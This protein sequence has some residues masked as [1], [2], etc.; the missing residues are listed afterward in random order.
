MSDDLDE[1]RALLPGVT[2]APVGALGG[3]D[4][5]AV[6]R[7]HA[8][9]PD[10][11]PGAAPTTV[12]VKTFHEP[13]GWVREASALEVLPPSA[14]APRF[15]AAGDSPPVVVM[16]DLGPGTSVADALLGP[17]PAAAVVA[18]YAWTDA[19]AAVHRATTGHRD[20][21]RA[22]LDSRSKPGRVPLCSLTAGLD[23][24]IGDL[25]DLC[26]PLGVDMS[27]AL[28][29]AFH[30][31]AARLADEAACTLSPS[32]ACPDNNVLVGDSLMLI[33]FEGAAWRHVAWDIAY[34]KVP[35][36]SCW[37]SWR[38]PD[39]VS[40][41]AVARYRAAMADHLPYVATPAFERDIEAATD[42]WSVVYSSWFLPRALDADIVPH[43]LEGPSR[44][45]LLLHRLDRTWRESPTPVIAAFAAS[46]RA[47]LV[48]RW[49]D[50]P[51]ALAPA[52]RQL[53]DQ[54][55]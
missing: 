18:V 2:L 24:T 55:R 16:S 29:D 14:P 50:I 34:L 6:R 4:R 17:D 20:A 54:P 21:F 10:A 23:T 40:A 47:E 48:D 39:E 38:L 26:A 42:L 45:A 35:W 30:A 27:P 25:R 49:G 51:L 31:E 3:S 28:V 15:I 44:R 36:P 43:D 8:T 37:C 52:F 33:D 41:G 53:A 9:W 46:L 12:I 19:I 11:E 22:A 1:A 13:H 7:A 32:D 5:S